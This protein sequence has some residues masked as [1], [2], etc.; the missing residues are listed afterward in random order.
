M[1]A[2]VRR[3]TDC[4]RPVLCPGSCRQVVCRPI[5]STLKRFAESLYWRQLGEH[6]YRNT[7]PQYDNRVWDE[8]TQFHLNTVKSRP[9]GIVHTGRQY[10]NPKEGL[11]Y[12]SGF[13]RE[14]N[15]IY[16]NL[17]RWLPYQ[18][19]IV[20]SCDDTRRNKWVVCVMFLFLPT[21]IVAHTLARL[22]K[23]PRLSVCRVA[24]LFM[25]ATRSNIAGHSRDARNAPSQA[26]WSATSLRAVQCNTTA[27][28]HETNE[29]A[30]VLKEKESW[31]VDCDTADWFCVTPPLLRHTKPITRF[32]LTTPH[33][34]NILIC[35]VWPPLAT[36]SVSYA[37][38]TYK[39]VCIPWTT[40]DGANNWDRFCQNRWRSTRKLL[41]INAMN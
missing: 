29:W 33:S 37:Y 28:Q 41:P 5:I 2:L 34:Q 13:Q 23:K 36:Q 24:I 27:C 32:Y 25:V 12:S 21:R 4:K 22:I 17:Q 10:C 7:F 9:E 40:V 18:H 19:T 38:K 11:W 1:F 30:A 16:S 20:H 26:R 35:F 39:S 14:F 15:Q 31:S 6:A 3:H 8:F